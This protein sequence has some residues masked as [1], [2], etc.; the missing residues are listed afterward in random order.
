VDR[1][2]LGVPPGECFGLLGINGAGKTTTF[3]MLTGDI[4]VTSGDAYVNGYSVTSQ[5]KK[6]LK[7]PVCF[8]YSD[9]PKKFF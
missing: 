8:L 2:N 6:V 3:K 9:F 1:L 5:I 4:T 7:F